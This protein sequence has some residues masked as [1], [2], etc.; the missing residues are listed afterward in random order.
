M[1]ERNPGRSHGSGKVRKRIGDTTRAE[2]LKSGYLIEQTTSSARRVLRHTGQGDSH[3]SFPLR[4]FAPSPFR[5]VSPTG[6][7]LFAAFA[8]T[9][10]RRFAYT[11]PCSDNGSGLRLVFAKFP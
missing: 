11:P 4:R 10:F 2:R 7:G 8:H 5:L 3:P 6:Q 1:M 9:P